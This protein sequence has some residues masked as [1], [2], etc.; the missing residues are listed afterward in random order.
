MRIKFKK[1]VKDQPFKIYGEDFVIPCKEGFPI[2]KN[3]LI[4]GS[5]GTRKCKAYLYPNVCEDEN[6]NYIIVAND[7]RA[8]DM[9][10]LLPENYCVKDINGKNTKF[11]PM[12]YLQTKQDVE[13]FVKAILHVSYCELS[14]HNKETKFDKAE[15]TYLALL[16]LITRGLYADSRGF[17]YPNDKYNLVTLNDF[18]YKEECEL[19]NIIQS[20]KGR[21]PNDELENTWLTYKDYIKNETE[22]TIHTIKYSLSIR[23]GF[24]HEYSDFF[25]DDNLSLH[26]LFEKDKQ[27]VVMRQETFEQKTKLILTLDV[28]SIMLN[29]SK[30]ATYTKFIL[31]DFLYYGNEIYNFERLFTEENY[32]VD[33]TAPSF[34]ALIRRIPNIEK[35]F[36]KN[37]NIIYTGTAYDPND[38]YFYELIKNNTQRKHKMTLKRIKKI[39]NTPHKE[40]VF[41]NG[42][43]AFVCNKYIC[44][45][46]KELIFNE[47]FNTVKNL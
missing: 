26:D 13:E 25:S 40:I 44:E 37:S 3:T 11:N 5:A 34:E 46:K 8:N 12:L 45:K 41:I 18:L 35:A 9:K 16:I 33:I 10:A 20:I 36:I 31:K 24:L 42:Y 30:F 4:I 32:S 27:A 2:T 19:E 1:A 14:K 17:N 6:S 47:Y 29:H 43:G 21:F 7:F 38:L 39:N 28:I 23:L 15:H 22:S